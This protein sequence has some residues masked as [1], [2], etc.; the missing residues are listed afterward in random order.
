MWSGDNTSVRD[1]YAQIRLPAAGKTLKFPVSVGSTASRL[2]QR[3]KIPAMLIES[4]TL[5]M[6]PLEK[7]YG[8]SVTEEEMRRAIFGESEVP[9]SSIN[10]PV[11]ETIP[12]VVILQPVKEAKRKK[13]QKPSRPD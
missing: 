10:S 5:Y 1:Q 7:W 11:Q 12:D 2:T 9:A 13:S 3:L 6:T 8:Y 4:A